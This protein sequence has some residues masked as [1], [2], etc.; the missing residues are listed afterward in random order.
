MVRE[1]YMSIETNFSHPTK[2]LN[3]GTEKL[4]GRVLL[5]VGEYVKY[6]LTEFD[7]TIRRHLAIRMQNPVSPLVLGIFPEWPAIIV[8]TELAEQAFQMPVRLGVPTGF[9]G[10]AESV[11]DPRHSTGVG[12]IL[13]GL[14]AEVVENG[15]VNGDGKEPMDRL[16]DWFR[17]LF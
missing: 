2:L 12:L 11:R 5:L 16:F 3:Q 9:T 15:S 14:D 1:V 7:D 17:G 4:V 13:H 6:P 10:L 8:L